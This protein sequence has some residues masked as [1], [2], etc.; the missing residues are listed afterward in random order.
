MKG[1]EQLTVPS[2]NTPEM[3]SHEQNRVRG[4]SNMFT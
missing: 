1:L 3:L 2:F 4:F